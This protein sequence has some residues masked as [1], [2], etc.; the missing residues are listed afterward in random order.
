M[1]SFSNYFDS[2]NEL[3]ETIMRGNEVSFEYQG[4]RYYV[5]PYFNND[6]VIKGACFGEFGG[7]NEVVFYSSEE[8]SNASVKNRPLLD[9]VSEI[10][11]LWSNF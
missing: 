1:S 10:D 4:V 11:I 2:I 5:L 3:Y 9:I 6:G 8:L 7:V